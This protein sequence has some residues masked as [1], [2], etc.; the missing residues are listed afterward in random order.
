MSKAGPPPTNAKRA[1]GE[2]GLVWWDDGTPDLNRHVVRTT[3]YAKTYRELRQ[4]IDG[5][6]STGYI[7]Q[8]K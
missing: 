5:A 4:V 7:P 1:L 6:A 8:I 3:A 2:R